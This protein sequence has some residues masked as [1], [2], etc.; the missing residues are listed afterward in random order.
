MPGWV[1]EAEGFNLTSAIPPCRDFTSCTE[2]P[3]ETPF[4]V[5]LDPYSVNIVYSL[6]N[7]R[8]LTYRCRDQG[9]SIELRR[10]NH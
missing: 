4:G 3:P 10:L 6:T 9:E 1:W 5:K 8:K 7:N 2:P